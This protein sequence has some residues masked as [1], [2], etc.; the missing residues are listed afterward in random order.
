LTVSPG[1]L[2]VVV[3]GSERGTLAY[4]QTPT[5]PDGPFT[6][7]GSGGTD[8]A[9]STFGKAFYRVIASA[10][11]TNYTVTATSTTA[12]QK[13]LYATAVVFGDHDGI[14][15]HAFGTGLAAPSVTPT[16]SDDY[17][18]IGTIYED[19]A[20]NTT[21]PG[22]TQLSYAADQSSLGAH[23]TFGG[24]LSSNAATGTRTTSTD[25]DTVQI[26]IIIKSLQPVPVGN[27]KF[28]PFFGAM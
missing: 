13:S 22:M 25:A 28:L 16:N 1:A 18:F 10:S 19:T 15:N 21:P 5:C 6:A 2:V 17:L 11:S 9:V 24:L 23:A 14:G 12:T 26:S 8:A 20:R 3:T 4:L 27:G 7:I